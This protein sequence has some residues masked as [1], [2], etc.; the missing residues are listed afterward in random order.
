M[1]SISKLFVIISSI[2]PQKGIDIHGQ[3]GFD[4]K[5]AGD[6][7]DDGIHDVLVSAPYAGPEFQIK[8]IT[9]KFN[10]QNVN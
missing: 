9:Q 8:C 1:T 2:K 7:N 4:I 3:F 5:N 10:K 6:L